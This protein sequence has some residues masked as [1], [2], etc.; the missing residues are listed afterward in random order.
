MRMRLSVFMFLSISAPLAFGQ[1]RPLRTEE[2]DLLPTGRIRADFGLEFLQK[3]KYSLSGL[4][5]DLTRLGVTSIHVGVGEY[6]EFQISGVLQD[7]LSISRKTTPVIPPTFS[8]NSTNDFGDIVLGTK[9]KFA[10]EKGKRPALAFRFAVQLPNAS[11]TT[12][13]GNDQ[14]EFYS[15]LMVSKHLKSL[16]LLGNAGL[17]ILQNPAQSGQADMLTYGAA[18][19][20]PIHRRINLVAEISGRR[21]PVRIGNEPQSYARAG[22]QINTGAV[23]WDIAGIA[24]FRKFDADSGVTVGVTFEFQGFH[25]SGKSRAP[26][27]PPPNR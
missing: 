21:G 10:S 11:Q 5:G 8:G 3:Q 23:R 22:A 15:Q 25:K 18:L 4:E 16:W 27:M 20:A 14:T 9:L 24:G 12:G 19:I 13:L 2:A 26:S 1:Q 17:A 6:A 7:Y